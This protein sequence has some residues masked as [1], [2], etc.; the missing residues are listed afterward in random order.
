[1]V[2]WTLLGILRSPMWFFPEKANIDETTKFSI[3]LYSS[4]R[5]RGEVL[6]VSNLEHYIRMN[7]RAARIQQQ[8]CVCVYTHTH[9][10]CTRVRDKLFPIRKNTFY[11][12]VL[13]LGAN[14]ASAQGLQNA[15]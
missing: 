9:P 13:K 7:I 3:T 8:L 12:Q 5:I 6:L 10:D 1:M 14:E 11:Q 4:I 2:F 15:R